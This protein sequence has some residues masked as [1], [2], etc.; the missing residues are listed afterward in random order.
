[1]VPLAQI[2][3]FTPSSAF[4]TFPHPLPFPWNYSQP[5]VKSK[6]IVLLTAGWLLLTCCTLTCGNAKIVLFSISTF[7][8]SKAT[9][10]NWMSKYIVHVCE[11]LQCIILCNIQNN[12]F[13][14]KMYHLQNINCPLLFVKINYFMQHVYSVSVHKLFRVWWLNHYILVYLPTVWCFLGF[15]FFSLVCFAKFIVGDLTR[16]PRLTLE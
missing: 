3:S 7:T 13:H 11:L 6:F 14:A 10:G 15:I 16:W 8:K 9:L 4:S 5:S 2:V 1:M 12:F